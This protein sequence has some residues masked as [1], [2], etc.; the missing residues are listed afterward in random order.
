MHLPQ[1]LRTSV[2][3]DMYTITIIINTILMMLTRLLHVHLVIHGIL[4]LILQR[5]YSMW[6]DIRVIVLSD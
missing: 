6:E 1:R 4:S 2:F 5:Q 3:K